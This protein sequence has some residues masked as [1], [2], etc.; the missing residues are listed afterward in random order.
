FGVAHRAQRRPG[1]GRARKNRALRS[2][3]QCRAANAL[4][5]PRRVLRRVRDPLPASADCAGVPAQRRRNDR[6][7]RVGPHGVQVE[8]PSPGEGPS[9]AWRAHLSPPAPPTITFLAWARSLTDR[10][11]M[12][13]L[14]GGVLALLLLASPAHAQVQVQITLGLPVVLPSMVVV[15]PGVQVVSELDDEI[16]FVGGWYWVRRGPHWYRTHDHRGRWLWVEPRYVPAALV[17]IPSG[18][19]RHIRHDEWRR[20]EHDRKEREKA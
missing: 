12:R 5:L 16:Y 14:F 11:G 20:M 2:S 18:Q 17:R 13:T 9:I 8:P 4:S 15:Q 10:A 3:L 19:Y 7:E 6:G 1:R